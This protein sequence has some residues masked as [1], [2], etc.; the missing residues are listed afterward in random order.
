VTSN[1]A[2]YGN[3]VTPETFIRVLVSSM[4]QG[5]LSARFP[6]LQPIFKQLMRLS[7][8]PRRGVPYCKD[9]LELTPARAL[10]AK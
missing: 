8:M 4:P 3:V 6:S 7:V 1:L 10:I 9:M 5:Q 2:L